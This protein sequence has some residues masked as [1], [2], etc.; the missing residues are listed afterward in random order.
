MIIFIDAK[1]AFVKISA[2][3]LGKNSQRTKNKNIL[4]Q[5]DINYLWPTSGQNMLCFVIVE[6][7]PLKSRINEWWLKD[8]HLFV[9]RMPNRHYS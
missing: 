2:L 3:I 1:K 6:T 9:K 4:S 7:F 5:H 8:R